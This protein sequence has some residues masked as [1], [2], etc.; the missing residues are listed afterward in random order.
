MPRFISG[1]RRTVVEL[2]NLSLTGTGRDGRWFRVTR[3]GFFIAE[4][5]TCAELGRLVNLADLSEV[6]ALAAHALRRRVNA[7]LR[8]EPPQPDHDRVRH[9]IL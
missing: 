6:L 9:V 1:D 4:V 3:D 5:R 7:L 8:L 2:I